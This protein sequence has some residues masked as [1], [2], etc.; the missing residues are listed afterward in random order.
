MSRVIRK[1]VFGSYTT[2]AVQSE[3]IARGLK[4]RTKEVER[5]YYLCSDNK[6]TELM[7]TFACAYAKSRFSPDGAHMI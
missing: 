6:G 1:P 3:K 5:L 4:F 2:R 7:W